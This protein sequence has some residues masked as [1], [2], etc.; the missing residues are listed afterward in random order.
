MLNKT[1]LSANDYLR[2][3]FMLAR[4]ILDSGW[5]PDDVIALWRGGAPV[6][7]AVHEFFYYHGLRPRHR[8]LKCRSYMGIES[9]AQEVAFEDSDGIFS[10]VAHGSRVL[11]IDDVFD[12]GGTARAVLE[13]LAPF[14]V[15]VRLATVYWK[16]SQN[17]T[18]IRPDFHVRQTEDWIVFPHELDGLTLDEVETKDPFVRALLK[19]DGN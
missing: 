7:V 2:D 19:A 9:R 16:P 11:V 18:D 8:A 4:M 10:S 17:K 1:Y 5:V 12:S 3:S 15:D 6:G 14:N 13:R